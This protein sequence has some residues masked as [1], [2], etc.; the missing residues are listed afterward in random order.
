MSSFL[1]RSIDQIG[2]TPEF[3]RWSIDWGCP[4]R[5][6]IGSCEPNRVERYLW[7]LASAS[8]SVARDE[9]IDGFCLREDAA[10]QTIRACRFDD[11]ANFYGGREFCE[12]HCMS[13]PVNV[14]LASADRFSSETYSLAGCF[15]WLVRSDAALDALDELAPADESTNRRKTGRAW[16]R[17]FAA[18]KLDGEALQA[19]STL[20]DSLA[21]R[22]ALPEDWRR[23]RVA[24]SRCTANRAAMAIQFVPAG[25]VVDNEWSIGPY[26]PDCLAVQAEA[27]KQCANCGRSGRPHPTL[28][29][30]SLGNRP[31]VELETLV[32]PAQAT[33]L[34]RRWSEFQS[35]PRKPSP[36]DKLDEQ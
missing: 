4:I 31:F 5:E 25:M 13:C 21:I 19:I 28:K 2:K 20:F 30:K 22:V 17:L 35:R 11:V 26:C 16:Y 36:S 34:V 3:V 33:Q 12:Q 6:P 8:H 14:G 1:S 27:E 24:V 15:G 9:V 7:A 32:G 29:R 10:Q 23:F 18:D